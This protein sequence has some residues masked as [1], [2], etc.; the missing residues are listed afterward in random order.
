MSEVK[1]PENRYTIY[2]EPQRG[3]FGLIKGDNMGVALHNGHDS[4]PYDSDPKH[5]TLEFQ[6]FGETGEHWKVTKLTLTE[7]S[8]DVEVELQVKK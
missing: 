4:T 8:L 5:R 7:L 3:L 6:L 1:Q 2:I